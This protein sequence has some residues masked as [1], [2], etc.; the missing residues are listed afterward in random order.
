MYEL[1]SVCL[2]ATYMN[3]DGDKD[4]TDGAKFQI[5]DKCPLESEI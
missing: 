2:Y 4:F 5:L 1:I 3:W